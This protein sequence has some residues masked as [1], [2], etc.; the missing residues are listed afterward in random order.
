MY[1]E[2]L[3]I[4]NKKPLKH[5]AQEV[6]IIHVEIDMN[7]SHKIPL[8]SRVKSHLHHKWFHISQVPSQP[9]WTAIK[10]EYLINNIAHIA[11]VLFTVVSIFL[12]QGTCQHYF[13]SHVLIIV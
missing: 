3:F 7:N 9:L 1:L 12:N 10:G 11:F 8:R 2:L 5:N 6:E 13:E 4:Q